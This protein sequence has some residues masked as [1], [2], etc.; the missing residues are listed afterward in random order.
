MAE[1]TKSRA[2]H[3]LGGGHKTSSK[4]GKKPHSI[5]IRRGKSGGFISE[6]HHLP[7]EDGSMNPPEE[8]VHPDMASLMSSIQSNMG[9]QGAAPAGSPSPDM[10]QGAPAPGGGAPAPAPQGATSPQP[11]M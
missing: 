4:S 7:D 1:K 11:G 9:D 8:H 5:H 10:S 6:H 3:V 2:S